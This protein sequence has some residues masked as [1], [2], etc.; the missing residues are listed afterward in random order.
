MSITYEDFAKLD[1]KIGTIKS[2]EVV[3]GAD[4]LLKLEVDI[5]DETRQIVSGIRE[6]FEDIQSL[7]GKQ[8][9]FLVNLEP[10]TIKGLESQGMILAVGGED[11]F[12]LLHP[13][14]EVPAGSLI[15]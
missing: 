13:S 4:R 5:G 10:R 7:V 3:D 9:P 6:Y 8:C 2:V 12:A 1:I 11:V 14:G 15:Q